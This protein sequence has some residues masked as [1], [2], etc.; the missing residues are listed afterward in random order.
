MPVV[1]TRSGRLRG[2]ERR[3]VLAFRGIPYAAPPSGPRRFRAPEPAESWP[4]VRDADAPGPGAPQ[5]GAT[6]G[7]AFTRIIGPGATSEDCLTLDLWTP[8]ADGAR[9]PVLVWIHGGAF[10]MGAGSALAYGGAALARSGDVV[11]VTLNYRLGALGFLQLGDLAPAA[12]FDSNLG[13]RDQ[14]AALEWVRDNVAAF[15]GDP[16]QVCVFGESA[17]AMSVGALLGAPRARGLFARAIAQSGAA[18]NVAGRESAAR[19]AATF[20][21]VLGLAP[22]EA[23]RLREL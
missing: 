14:I 5:R 8:A 21:D 6:L 13:L 20:L 12:G 15:G 17:G 2:T 11:V 7:G 22:R 18:H 19:V 3:G 9:R 16:A 4:G 23:A 10:L 1:E